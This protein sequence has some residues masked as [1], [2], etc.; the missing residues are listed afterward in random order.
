MRNPMNARQVSRVELSL[1]TVDGFVFWTKDAGN[2][3][4]DLAELAPYPFYFSYTINAYSRTIERRTADFLRCRLPVIKDLLSDLTPEQ[5]VWRYD[6]ILIRRSCTPEHHKRVFREIASHL[7]GLTTTCETSFLRM[8]TKTKR[9]TKDIGLQE[10]ALEEKAELLMDLGRIAEEYGI[11]LRVCSDPKLAV[12]SGLET[13]H[14]IDVERLSRIAGRPMSAPRDR[15]QRPECGCSMSIDIGAYD[16]CRH[17]CLYC[18]ATQHPQNERCQPLFDQ[19]LPM[20][21]RQLGPDDVVRDRAMPLFSAA[22][23]DLFSMD[24]RAVH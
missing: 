13:A 20:L 11:Q 7:C 6:P 23:A 1:K 2:M 21:G 9:N 18:Y 19:S 10:I 17:G 3:L 16:T 15:N 12:A 5:F 24:N 14:C 4:P 8:Y 22:Q